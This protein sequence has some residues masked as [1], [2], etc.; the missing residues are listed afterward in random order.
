VASS[1]GTI[2]ARFRV[3]DVSQT[4]ARL[5]VLAGIAPDEFTLTLSRTGK[6]RRRCRTVWRLRNQIGVQFGC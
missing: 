6:A 4:G 5:Q 3:L 1:N 2:A